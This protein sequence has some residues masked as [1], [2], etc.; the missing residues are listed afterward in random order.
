MPDQHRSSHL[1]ASSDADYP[2]AGASSPAPSLSS[3]VAHR[4][5][6]HICVAS[7]AAASLLGLLLF[8]FPGAE[9]SEP[10]TDLAAARPAGPLDMFPESGTEGPVEIA[11]ATPPEADPMAAERDRPDPAD[12]SVTPPAEVAGTAAPETVPEATIVQLGK[13]DTLARVLGKL[14][15]GATEASEIASLLGKHV[16]LRSLAVGQL[17]RV[18]LRPPAPAV[19]GEGDAVG[20]DE[21]PAAGAASAD[22]APVLQAL[23]IRPE[24]RREVTVGRNDDG[25]LVID[26]KVF[27]IVRNTMRAAG[28]IEGSVV[29]SAEAA[30]VP[31][32]ALAEMLKAFSWDVNFQHDIKEG[33]RF[34]VLVE[35]A[36]TEDGQAVDGG[37]LLWAELTTGGGARQFAVYRFKPSDGEEFFYDEDGENV[38][39]AL[40]RTPLNMSRVSSGFGMRRHPILKFSRL[41]A[42]IDFAAPP[43]TP[44]LAAGDGRV[45]E[46]GRK[47]GYGN[48]VKIA[49]ANGMATGYA[50]MSRIGAGVRRSARIRQGQVIG[51]VGSTGMSTGPHLHFELHQA[52]KPVDPLAIARSPRTRLAGSELR[53]F[54]QAM[55][56]ID[57]KRVAT[58][59]NAEA[60]PP[61]AAVRPP[62]QEPPQ[63]APQ[64]TGAPAGPAPLAS[65]D[66]D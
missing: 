58:P 40:L 56:E 66:A 45:V 53:R 44:I 15:V 46:A 18:T 36:W 11:L 47:G 17:L 14:G 59:V 62:S 37:R 25:D 6:R 19:Q 55:A 63:E 16:P 42:G 43:G 32:Q 31:P 52:G 23:S 13:G 30:G 60:G 41:H 49:H 4:A 22:P 5:I 7:L 54:R 50:H 39:K 9:T 61:G 27:D 28:A 38:V 24:A 12:P 20:E 33:D 51:F 34:E 21:M 26:Q 57:R 29:G 10:V 64:A 48:W 3:P 35:R 8:R 1:I 2:R 65:G